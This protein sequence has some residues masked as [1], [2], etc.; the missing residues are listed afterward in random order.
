MG[1]II[2]LTA[3]SGAGK[4][5]IL[6]RLNS[7]KLF[8]FSVSVTTRA[9]REG[10]EDGVDYYF[11]SEE[12]FHSLVSEGK[13]LE[14]AVVHGNFYGTLFSEVDQ[15]LSTDATLLLELN[16]EGASN[17]KAYYPTAVAIMILP[18]SYELLSERLKGR[19]T[20]SVQV[21]QK[22]LSAARG[23][24]KWGIDNADYFI[25]NAELGQA[26]EDF[27]NIINTIK[28]KHSVFVENNKKYLEEL[29]NIM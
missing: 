27:E 10:E 24:I 6:G 5:T 16:P 21:V 19:A 2:T 3:P 11:V 15:I 28:C 29:I 23:E 8:T 1:Q 7:K 22:R 14:T 13:F 17:A 9:P 26:V 18:P 25:I 4:S 20:D 12:K